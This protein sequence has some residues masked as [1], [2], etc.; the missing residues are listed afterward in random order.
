VTPVPPPPPAPPPVVVEASPPAEPAAAPSAEPMSLQAVEKRLLEPRDRD[1]VGDALLDF[2]AAR[3]LRVVLLVARKDEVASW[4]WRGEGIDDAHLGAYRVDFQQPSVFLNLRQGSPA[5]RGALPPMAAHRNLL[6]CWR[7]AEPEREVIV[8]PVRLKDRLVAAIYAEPDGPT[9]SPEA[10][11]DL[12]RVAAKTA[13]A[14]ELLIMRSKL[15][16]A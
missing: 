3:F 7:D 2:L 4:K 16:N 14:F 9:P 8:A 13:I 5:F 15:K 11:A 1:Q 10:F 12:Q 6:F